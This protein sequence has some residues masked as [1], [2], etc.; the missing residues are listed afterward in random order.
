MLLI[1][2]EACWPSIKLS[3]KIKFELIELFPVKIIGN[4]KTFGSATHL[5]ISL[6]SLR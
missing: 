3:R 4:Y 6:L 2:T 1:N 5:R